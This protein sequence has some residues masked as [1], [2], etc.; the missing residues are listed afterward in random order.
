MPVIGTSGSAAARAVGGIGNG[1]RVAPLLKST[2]IGYSSILLSSNPYYSST[3]SSKDILIRIDRYNWKYSLNGGVTWTTRPNTTGEY[4]A[5]TSFGPYGANVGNNGFMYTRTGGATA[6]LWLSK[7]GYLDDTQIYSSNTAAA[8]A[9][10]T[11]ALGA[12]DGTN[13]RA[14]KY[15]NDRWITINTT[16]APATSLGYSTDNGINW[17]LVSSS[18][19]S[20]A[21]TITGSNDA[22]NYIRVDNPDLSNIA[23]GNGTWVV[24]GDKIRYSTNFT[25]WT[26]STGADGTNNSQT[27]QYANVAFVNNRFWAMTTLP[28]SYVYGTGTPSKTIAYSNDGIS[29]TKINNL[30]GRY[31]YP[32]TYSPKLNKLVMVSED[33]VA[34]SDDNG[35]TWTE[36]TYNVGTISGT[37]GSGM[38]NALIKVKYL[39]GKFIAIGIEVVAYSTD[40]ISWTRG[41]MSSGSMLKTWGSLNL[42]AGNIIVGPAGR[43]YYGSGLLGDGSNVN[44]VLTS[45]DGIN[46][47][48]RS[49]PTS[50]TGTW[51]SQ[52]FAGKRPVEGLLS[53][54][55]QGSNAQAL[56]P[57][58]I[59]TVPT[60][61]TATIQYITINN[62]SSYDIVYDL[63]IL[64]AN[65]LLTSS[66][67]RVVDAEVPAGKTAWI[68]YGGQ[69]FSAGQRVV[70]Y[71]SSINEIVVSV[72]GTEA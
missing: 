25:T 69:T 42:S 10:I 2:T 43:D 37:A 30:T 54:G 34:Y 70:A 60:G 35:V 68:Y 14:I 45:A 6:G 55:G 41:T 31:I 71:S 66:N 26:D 5:Q 7:G 72:F 33:R 11:V 18:S 15:I 19:L 59:Y 8:A 4:A 62:T 53:I 49:L 52:V 48:E 51:N 23:F 57:V 20:V 58:D 22:T 65:T 24:V 44:T 27:I 13:T 21:S 38:P 63:G 50:D 16:S 32:P 9:G 17:S 39:R 46:W 29:W 47:T 36:N 40:G 28:G 64:A 61:K 56:T 12:I 3:V 1:F 67:S